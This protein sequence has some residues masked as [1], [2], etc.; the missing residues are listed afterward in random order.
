MLQKNK[1]QQSNVGIPTKTTAPTSSAKLPPV[2]QK[3]NYGS[4]QIPDG[5]HE[6]LKNKIK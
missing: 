6:E 3:R 1:M 2:A 4:V 5:F